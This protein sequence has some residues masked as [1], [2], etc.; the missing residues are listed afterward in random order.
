M[1]SSKEHPQGLPTSGLTH[2]KQQN[3]SVQ[4]WKPQRDSDAILRTCM[5]TRRV[6]LH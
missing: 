4:T 3:S 5:N 2:K 6:S 1:Y